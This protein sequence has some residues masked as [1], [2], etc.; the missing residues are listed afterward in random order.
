MGV[1][2]L[3]RL[4]SAASAV[5]LGEAGFLTTLIESYGITFRAK[6]Q[7][8]ASDEVR[9]ISGVSSPSETLLTN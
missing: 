6:S 5:G 4:F 7:P 9:M 2:N 1:D 8:E 3:E